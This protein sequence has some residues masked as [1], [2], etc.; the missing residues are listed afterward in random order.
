MNYLTPNA[1]SE[2]RES[3]GPILA[4]VCAAVLG[5]YALTYAAG[6]AAAKFLPLQPSEAVYLISMLQIMLYVGIVIW[7]FSVSAKRAWLTLFMLSG[8]CLALAYI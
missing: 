6:L 3:W 8:L 1:K 7:V 2:P 5:G 4:R